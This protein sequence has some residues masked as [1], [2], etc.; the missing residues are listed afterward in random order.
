[1]P[2]FLDLFAK[3]LQRRPGYTAAARQVF[4]RTAAEIGT[5]L[6][7]PE[8]PQELGARAIGAGV[9]VA[10]R[11]VQDLPPLE[12]VAA[13]RAVAGATTRA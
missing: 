13:L 11:R 12:A 7:G 6:T 5:H 1:L 9:L 4:S 3:A 10:F 8:A 2:L